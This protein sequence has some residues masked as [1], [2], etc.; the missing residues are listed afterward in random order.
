MVNDL[1]EWAQLPCFGDR[2]ELSTVAIGQLGMEAKSIVCFLFSNRD[3][4]LAESLLIFTQ[5]K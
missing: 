3:K 2:R 1:L 5:R 4:T